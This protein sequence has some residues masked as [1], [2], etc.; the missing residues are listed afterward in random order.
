MDSYHDKNPQIPLGTG[1]RKTNNINFGSVL[2]SFLKRTNLR[3]SR[4][5]NWLKSGN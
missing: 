2:G 5:V 3:D 1:G 4:S